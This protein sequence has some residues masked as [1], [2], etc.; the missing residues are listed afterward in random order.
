MIL[1]Q[2]STSPGRRYNS[3]EN[4]NLLRVLFVLFIFGSCPVYS[5]GPE[6]AIKRDLK[7]NITQ[8]YTSQGAGFSI[9]SY[10]SRYQAGE[11]IPLLLRVKNIGN[12]P[13][14]LYIHKNHLLNFTIIV[15]DEKGR[16]LPIKGIVY[17][18]KKNPTEDPF[19]RDHTGTRHNYRAIILQP[20]ETFEKEIVLQEIVDFPKKVSTIER[21]QIQA[22]FYPNPEQA[23]TIFLK[24][25]NH[26]T[27]FI[28]PQESRHTAQRVDRGD[29]ETSITPKEVVYLAL[30]AEYSREWKNFF[31][32]VSIPDL[33]KDYPE[34][35]RR[36]VRAP[37]GQKAA[38]LDDFRSYLKGEDFHRLLRFH[39]ISNK[40]NKYLGKRSSEIAT[41]QAEATREIEGFRRRFLYTYYL[42]KAQTLWKI[43]GVESQVLE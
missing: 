5:Q 26:Y 9:A 13:I 4:R 31:R 19:F 30:S 24:S 11:D 22:Y 35:A 16:N 32:Y 36:Y 14:T 41:V 23:G 21:F 25:N 3:Q 20:D 34:Y 29:D 38:I 1:P 40:K 2:M 8:N 33:I 12:Y 18:T 37:E 39:I 7:G 42:T 15:R 27:I 28:D 17:Q 10:K 43:T 6:L